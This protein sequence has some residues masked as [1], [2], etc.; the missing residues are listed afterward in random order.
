[1]SITTEQSTRLDAIFDKITTDYVNVQNSYMAPNGDVVYLS[2]DEF[3]DE[4]QRIKQAIKQAM[5]GH[6]DGWASI[7]L[8]TLDYQIIGPKVTGWANIS[9]SPGPCRAFGHLLLTVARDHS[10]PVD[11]AVEQRTTYPDVPDLLSVHGSLVEKIKEWA[12]DRTTTIA[13]GVD[14]QMGLL[15]VASS[16][17]SCAAD[18][19]VKVFIGEVMKHKRWLLAN[20][21]KSQVTPEAAPEIT[22]EGEA[23]ITPEVEAVVVRKVAAAERVWRQRMEAVFSSL[24]EEAINRNW[25]SE[26]E[27]FLN[28][29]DGQVGIDLDEFRRDQEFEVTWTETYTVTVRCTASGV[30]APDEEAAINEVRDNWSYGEQ[31]AYDLYMMN[32]TVEY[33]DADDWSAE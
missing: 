15:D 30:T 28:D 21:T 23:G 29:M 32:A 18:G 26:Y 7:D 2:G 11:P 9:W 31:D 1:M 24:K 6:H 3:P 14:E 8:G 19:N 25:C 16:C 5:L 17:P 13:D 12:M 4:L 10:L 33:E 27:S 22:P 20:P